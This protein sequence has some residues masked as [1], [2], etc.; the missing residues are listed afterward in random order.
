LRQGWTESAVVYL[1]WVPLSAKLLRLPLSLP[2][3]PSAVGPATFSDIS[4]DFAHLLSLCAS[5]GI[6]LKV[7]QPLRARDPGSVWDQKSS[8]ASRITLV[9]IRNHARTIVK[10]PR[11]STVRKPPVPGPGF[12]KK[13]QRSPFSKSPEILPR[14]LR[15]VYNPT[16]SPISFVFRFSEAQPPAIASYIVIRGSLTI[17]M[18]VTENVLGPL[19]PGN[20]VETSIFSVNASAPI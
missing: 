2:S 18:S 3:S 15:V 8:P 4:L 19:T 10:H 5:L 17:V 16:A 11:T 7:F 14:F 13:S 1:P 20:G 12:Q 6:D 9:E